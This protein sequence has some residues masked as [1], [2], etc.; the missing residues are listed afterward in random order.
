MKIMKNHIKSLFLL[1][2]LTAGFALFLTDQMRAQTFT[3]LH[4]FTAP[5]SGVYGNT[6]SDGILPK[7]GLIISGNTLYGTAS[8]SG[9]G[10]FGTVFALNTDGTSFATLYS[11]KNNG[12]AGF[13]LSGVILSGNTLYGSMNEGGLYAKGGGLFCP[14][15]RWHELY[16][17]AYC[18][19]GCL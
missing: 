9:P 13:P 1:P 6:N 11:F 18:H 19:G 17:P 7:A 3:T 8:D 10:G 15:H 2:V 14:E 4:S 12:Y 16:E 5:S